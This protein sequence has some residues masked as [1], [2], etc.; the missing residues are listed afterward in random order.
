MNSS[1]GITF[2]CSTTIT[3]GF[4]LIAVILQLSHVKIFQFFNEADRRTNFEID[5][6]EAWADIILQPDQHIHFSRIAVG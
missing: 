6:T 2:T 5:V 3:L 1:I 4:L